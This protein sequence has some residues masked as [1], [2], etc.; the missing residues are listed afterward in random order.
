MTEK[1]F[2]YTLNGLTFSIRLYMDGTEVKAE[3]TV[4]EGYADFNAFYWGDDVNDGSSTKLAD[5][6]LNMNGAQY[7][8][9]AVDWDG[10]QKLSS[11][12]LGPAGQDKPTFLTAGESMT[13]TLAG[14][15]SLDEV[16]YLG[17][18]ATSTSTP[19]G[20]IKAIDEGEEICPPPP[21]DDFP[22]WAQ[23]ISNITFVFDQ[24]E[25][26]TKPKPDGDG[27]YTVKVDVAAAFPDDLDDSIDALLQAMI[28]SDMLDLDEDADLLGVVIKGGLQITQF[29]AY[30]SHNTNGTDPDPLPAGI[31]FAL[32]GDHGNVDP[33]NAIDV[34]LH[35]DDLFA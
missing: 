32:P 9:A 29:Y 17:V 8:G 28:D 21:K 1:I 6:A 18:R 7:E 14:V 3:V 22:E 31:G 12:G 25:G 26:D 20:S 27:Y 34:G 16:D 2:E 19:E 4:Q 33:T 30:G 23:D 10:A 13:F 35:Y 24:T 5:K 15:T 11:A